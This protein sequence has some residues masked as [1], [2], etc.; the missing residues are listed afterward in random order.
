MWNGFFGLLKK[1]FG[2]MLSG[3]LFLLTLGSLVLYCCYINFVY[4]KLDQ[5]IY[6]VYLYDSQ[7]TQSV[8]SHYA[9]RVDS[10]KALEEACA[11]RYAVGI[12][13]SAGKPE[14]Y[15]LSSGSKTADHY[16]MIWGEG[17][18]SGI[19][20]GQAEV[21]GVNDKNMKN[22]REITAEFL[23]F[24][25]C[26]VGFLGLASM[27]FKEKQMG[28]IRVHGILPVR[29]SMFIFS[30]LL[31][32][33]LSDLLFTVLLTCINLGFLHA[34]EVL[35]AVLVQAGILSLLMT[36][37]GFLCA[38]R[39]PDFKQFSL[40]YLVL[41]VFVTTPV[42]LAGQIGIAWE[43]I[44]YHPMYHLFTAMKCAYFSMPT[45]N[46][47]YYLSCFGAIILL[48]VLTFRTLNREMAK[49]G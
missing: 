14:V 46:V 27:L 6:P 20:D 44:V 4:V 13:L 19:V 24:E 11:D 22:R 37:V 1:D 2:L 21:I 39:L 25:L 23:F 12:D 8:T 28:V 29:R 15:L 26:A 5:K 42:F 33:L 38:V 18:L 31:V 40:F 7:N 36:L 47:S 32:L 48:Y 35:P 30:K 9:T 43:W 10:R 45:T 49:E 41:A 34:P 16:R 3:R 17:V